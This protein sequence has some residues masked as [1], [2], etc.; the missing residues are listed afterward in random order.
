M[1]G[2]LLRLIREEEAASMMEYALVIAAGAVLAAA[3][4][5][6]LEGLMQT[7]TDGAD[8]EITDFFTPTP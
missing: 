2:E 5:P 4:R 7:V 3:L 1:K 6:T 8:S